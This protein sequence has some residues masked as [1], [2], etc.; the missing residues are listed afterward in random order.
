MSEKRLNN[1]IFLMYL[2]TENYCKK[3]KISTE[4]F[5]KLDEKYAILN[6][7]AECPDVFD[8]LTNAEM[9][10]EIEQYVSQT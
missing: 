5:I 3:N 7:V 8:C 9:I 4:E 6:Y 10:E 2:V 1:T